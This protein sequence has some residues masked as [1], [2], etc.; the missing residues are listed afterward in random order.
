MAWGADLGISG[1]GWT[2]TVIPNSS[3]LPK[4]PVNLIAEGQYNKGPII[5]GTNKYEWA[6][7]QQ[8]GLGD[9]VETV[10]EYEAYLNESYGPLASTLL[11]LYPAPSDELANVALASIATDQA[12]RC[13]TRTLA[14]MTSAMGSSVW[15]YSFDLL[16]AIH[17]MEIP[18]V[19][20]NPSEALAPVL[21]EAVI[22]TM[23]SHWTEF[24]KNGNP[25]TKGQ[26]EWPIYGQGGDQHLVIDEVSKAGFGLQQAQCDF[27][28]S[29][30]QQQP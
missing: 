4:A 26:S 27:W 22:E 17:A 6:L 13:P 8:I 7:F 1:A 5:M 24:A 16:P 20:G 15:L 30:G 18:Y 28:D 14:R 3:V 9:T 21:N 25:N 23:Q 2:P 11:A 19:F 29:L 10:A 12:F